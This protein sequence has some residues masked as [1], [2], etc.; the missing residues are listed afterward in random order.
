MQ[1]FLIVALP[2]C[3]LVYAPFSN[4]AEEKKGD[5]NKKEAK[6]KESKDPLSKFSDE[7][8]IKIDFCFNKFVEAI[9]AKDAKLV[10]AFL[11]EIPKNLTKLDLN[12][13]ADQKEFLKAFAAFE[14]AELVSSQRIAAGGIGQVTYRDKSGKEK[15]QRMQN[16]GGRWKLSGL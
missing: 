10:A 12:K 2:V 6:D 4:A 16:L 11:E 7:D 3:L 15:T 14:G 1:R 5:K 9:G 8:L 13:E